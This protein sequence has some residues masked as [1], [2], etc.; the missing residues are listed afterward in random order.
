LNAALFDVTVHS[1]GLLGAITEVK[2]KI[3]PE[4]GIRKCIYE[5]LSWDYFKDAD[6]FEDVLF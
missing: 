4:F 5:N 2:M 6:L 3:E 1:F